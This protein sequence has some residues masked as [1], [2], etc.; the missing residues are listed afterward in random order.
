M[1]NTYA[2]S[3]IFILTLIPTVRIK[4][5]VWFRY[6]YGFAALA[7]GLEVGLWERVACRELGESA[8]HGVPMAAA[9][10]AAPA[11][12]APT[13]RGGGVNRGRGDTYS[14]IKKETIIAPFVLCLRRPGFA[15]SFA[16]AHA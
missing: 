4:T 14:S 2:Y 1:S 8:A 16:D 13:D 3:H 9:A 5:L 15:R 7:S 11:S 10:A 6:A 12:G